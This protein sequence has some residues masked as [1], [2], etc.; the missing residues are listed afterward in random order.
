MSLFFNDIIS[1][2]FLQISIEISGFH[3]AIVIKWVHKGA[4]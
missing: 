3:E 1:L 2:K 4:L